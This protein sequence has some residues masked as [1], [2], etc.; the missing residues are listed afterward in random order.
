[1]A[2]TKG[3]RNGDG[4]GQPPRVRG[5]E[6]FVGGL[7]R[8]VT[9]DM[10]RELFSSCGEVV[11]IRMMKDQNGALKGYC[12]VRFSTKEAASKA[13]KE[14]NNITLQGKKIGVASSTDK[15]I[16]F[17]GN[18]RKDWVAE[19]VDSMV[20]QAFQDVVSVELAMPLSTGES[21]PDKKKQNRGFAF[22]RFSSHAAAARAHR[23]GSKQDFLLGG[24]WHPVVDWAESEPEVDPTELAKVKIAFV[25]N[26]PSS[27]NED[28]LR[29]LFEPYGKL[30]RVA[31]SR[32]SNVPVGFV[33][34]STRSEL[35]NAIKELDGKS[36]DGPDKGPKFKIQVT[37]AKP[38]DKAKKRSREDTQNV[39]NNKSAIQGKPL[40]DVAAYNTLDYLN[41]PAKGPRLDAKPPLEIPTVADPYEVA[42]LSLPASV[43]DRLLRIFRQGLATRYDIDI[44]C[45]ESLRALPELTAATVLEQFASTK[46]E[47]ARNKGAY[48]V[49]LIARADVNAR[50]PLLQQGRTPEVPSRDAGLLGI[51]GTTRSALL[52]PLVASHP[53][54]GSSL[55]RHDPYNTA[56]SLVGLSQVSPLVTTD[57]H[58]DRRSSGLD[59]FHGLS[60]YRNP[61]S[62]GVNLAAGLMDAT[63][64]ERRP[65]PVKFDP[66]TGLPYKFDPFTG[67]PLQQSGSMPHSRVTGK[68]Y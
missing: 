67:E 17:L 10:V 45:L 18:L 35:D 12:F 24:K 58:I 38:A 23:A 5:S 41:F 43:T 22:V 4:A 15:D 26:L 34:F 61:A 20:R 40:T 56:T 55:L 30:E 68:Y 57:P 7:A 39:S 36:I 21:P 25:A 9:E 52:D 60:S 48:L 64:T 8:S 29:K 50:I 54:P 13:Q 31:I 33:H 2:E 42:V 1:M 14:K 19:E 3:N 27:A 51:T 28:F 37:V 49:N 63:A 6:V 65:P 16:L 59:D 11:E 44:Q 53:L 62:T 32:K 46:F 47:D 66:F